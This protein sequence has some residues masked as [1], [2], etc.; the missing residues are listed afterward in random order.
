MATRRRDIMKKLAAFGLSF[1]FATIVAR[2]AFLPVAF[3]LLIPAISNGPQII[4]TLIFIIG[5][6]LTI[7]IGIIIFLKTY[8]YLNKAFQDM[9]TVEKHG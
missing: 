8:K 3:V 1:V 2:I 7:T 9:D 4:P 5:I 6:V